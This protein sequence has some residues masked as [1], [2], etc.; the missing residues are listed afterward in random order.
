M[1]TA[2]IVAV[3]LALWQGAV[4]AGLLPAVV[5]A[6]P[7]E[8]A[9][10]AV[11]DGARFLDA[12]ALTALEVAVAAV[13]ACS[14]GIA[15]G[16]VAGTRPR[17]AHVASPVLSSLFAVPLT[18]VYPVF[19]VWFGLGPGSK[20]AFASVLGYFPVAINTLSGVRAVDPRYA[21]MARVMGAG[22]IQAFLRVILPLALPAIASGLRVGIGLVVIGVLGSEVVASLGGIGYLIGEHRGS[23]DTGHVYL[24]IALALL[25]VAAVNRAL[26]HLE[27]RV[28]FW[29]RPETR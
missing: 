23:L 7:Y 15:T 14:A 1:R 6:S 2:L 8:I 22:R 11:H 16:L 20:I 19:I 25:L 28:S 29:R 13:F 18:I 17:L 26:R 5:V 4:D 3:L 24:G 10:A 9:M 27:R 12:L 21:R